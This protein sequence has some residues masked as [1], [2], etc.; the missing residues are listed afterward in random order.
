MSS[1]VAAYEDL[2]SSGHSLLVKSILRL[3]FSERS[4]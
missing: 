2:L 4:P 1:E 3:V